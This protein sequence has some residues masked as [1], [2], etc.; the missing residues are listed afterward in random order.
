VPAIQHVITGV[1]SKLDGRGRVL[2]RYSGTEPLL[3]I[4]I[5]GEDQTAVQ[6]WANEIADA[7]KKALGEA[8]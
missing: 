4:M 1:E 8:S 2:I 6:T 7:A 5:E 3:R